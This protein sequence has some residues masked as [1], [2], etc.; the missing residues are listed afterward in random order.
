MRCAELSLIENITAS[1]QKHPAF[2]LKL[3]SQEQTPLNL[4]QAGHH[5]PHNHKFPF[6]N[7]S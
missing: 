7:R 5:R 6:E 4:R 3:A 2:Q 1:A